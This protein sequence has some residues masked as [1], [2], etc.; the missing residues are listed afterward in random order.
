MVVTWEAR[1]PLVLVHL[2]RA[3]RWHWHRRIRRTTF[4]CYH[5][6]FRLRTLRWVMHFHFRVMLLPAARL[7]QLRKLSQEHKLWIHPT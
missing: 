4:G 6:Y 3:F 7:T 2:V 5:G 1:P